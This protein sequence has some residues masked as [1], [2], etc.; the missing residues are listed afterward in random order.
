[1]S[2]IQQTLISLGLLRFA[3]SIRANEPRLAVTLHAIR[4]SCSRGH[5][6]AKAGLGYVPHS[7]ARASRCLPSRGQLQCKAC[8][9][10]FGAATLRMSGTKSVAMTKA[11]MMA[12]KASAKA[13]VDASR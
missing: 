13:M 8:A 7:A 1:M 2:S 12:R 9:G 5:L 4:E 11:I 10:P 6:R 3:G